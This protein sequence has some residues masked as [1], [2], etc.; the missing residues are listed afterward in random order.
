MRFPRGIVV[1][2]LA[3][4]AFPSAALSADPVWTPKANMPYSGMQP[5]AI[6]VNGLIYLMGGGNQTCGVA[7][8]AGGDVVRGDDLRRGRGDRV[9]NL[10]G[11]RRGLVVVAT[12]GGVN[13][14]KPFVVVNRRAGR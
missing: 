14:R 13:D 4:F 1:A 2:L 11:R 6:P 8:G 7:P 3:T 5:R 9:R 12:G 10:H